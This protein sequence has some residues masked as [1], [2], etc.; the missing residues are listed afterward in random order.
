MGKIIEIDK[1]KIKIIQHGIDNQKIRKFL[2]SYI[3][4]TVD[5]LVPVRKIGRYYSLLDGHSRGSVATSLS[6]WKE[7]PL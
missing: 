1:E 2:I 4:N 3:S 7:I 5:I 6:K